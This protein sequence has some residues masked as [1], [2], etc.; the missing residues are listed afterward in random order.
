MKEDKAFKEKKGHGQ[1]PMLETRDGKVLFESVAIARY[2]ISKSDSKLLGNGAFQEAQVSQWT[3][4]ATST[5]EPLLKQIAGHLFGHKIDL[6][7]FDKSKQNLCS[8]LSILEEHMSEKYWFVGNSLTLADIATFNM[9]AIPFCF[10]IDSN[11]RE[12][13]PSVSAWWD[14]MSKLSIISKRTGHLKW[15]EKQI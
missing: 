12:E 14:K 7:L 2:L 9:L 3:S 10:V 1:Y 4:F 11:L 13:Y 6:D 15:C 5:L 8:A